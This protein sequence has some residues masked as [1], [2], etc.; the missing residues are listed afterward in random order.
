MTV[1]YEIDI[2]NFEFWSGAKQFAERLT[3]SEWELISSYV[4]CEPWSWTETQ[5]NDWF[6]VDNE[7]IMIEILGLN[8]NEIENFYDRPRVSL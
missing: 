5:L 7:Y 1:T 8:E 6:W 3:D 2:R 4:E